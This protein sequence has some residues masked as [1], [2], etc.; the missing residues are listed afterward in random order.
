MSRR[1]A[2]ASEHLWRHLNR[3]VKC[4]RQIA[5]LR[6]RFLTAATINPFP[7]QWP[8]FI[9]EASLPAQQGLGDEHPIVT[10][11]SRTLLTAPRVTRTTTRPVSGA[12]DYQGPGRPEPGPLG[13]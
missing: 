1:R 9:N 5:L 2:P 10:N 11:S 4:V 6:L 8:I 13:A 3:G 12:V 7:A